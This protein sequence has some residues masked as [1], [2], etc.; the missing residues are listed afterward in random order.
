KA[1]AELVHEKSIE[2]LVDVGFCV[3]DD[4]VLTLLDSAGFPVD[5]ESQMVT[6]TPELL[7]IALQTIPGDVVL[8]NRNGEAL[9]HFGIESCFMGAGTPVNVFDLYS[10]EHRSATRQD[11]RQLVTIQDAL[12]QVDIVRPTVTA[13][14]QGEYSDLVEI[15]ELLRNTTKPIVHRTLSPDRV[16]AAAEMLFSVVG[17]EKAFHAKP[18]FA[19]LYCP[20]SPGYFTPENVHCMLKWAE[21]GVPITLLSMAM[22]G[23]SAPVTL[24]GELI[25]INTDILAWIVVLQNLYP[26]TPLLYGSVSAVLDMKTG[27]LPL[28]APERGMINSGAAIMANYYGIHSMCGGLSTDH[29]E[30][31]AQAGFE[32]TNTAIPLLQEGASI[33]YGVGAVDAGSAISYQQMIFDNEIIAGIRRMW[34]GISV[35]DIK[36]EIELI[37]ALTPRGNFLS[38]PHTLQNYRRH[39]YPE[40]ISRDTYD[41][42]KEKGETI[43]QICSRKAQEIV[44]NHQPPPLPASVEAE[45]ERIMRRFLPDFSYEG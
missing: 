9:P 20:I 41:T 27:L 26:K 14:D 13:T 34:A 28:G 30:L 2:I 39:W 24:L 15:A 42:W 40:I 36:E 16:D 12:P 18:H 6:I 43:D 35:H 7:E 31:D 3:P 1:I 22:G 21:Y 33:I 19:T 4:D 11:V 5:R 25:V 37:K 17:G 29:K 10:G 32:K 8:H 44:A 23:A 45:I 38:A